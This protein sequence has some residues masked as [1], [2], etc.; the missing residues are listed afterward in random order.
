MGA[1]EEAVK[2]VHR[3]ASE[4]CKLV[5]AWKQSGKTNAAIQIELP[6]EVSDEMLQRV[7]RVAAEMSDVH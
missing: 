4:W 7:P 5:S 6:A 3:S 1:K 2:Q